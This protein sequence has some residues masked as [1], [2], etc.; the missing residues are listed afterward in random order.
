MCFRST[1]SSDDDD[2]ELSKANKFN[3]NEVLIL[4]LFPDRFLNANTFTW[5]TFR[6]EFSIRRRDCFFPNIRLFITRP[7]NVRFFTVSYPWNGFKYCRPLIW[8]TKTTHSTR[9]YFPIV[10]PKKN[11]LL[12]PPRIDPKLTEAFVAQSIHVILFIPSFIRV[13]RTRIFTIS[14]MLFTVFGL[15]RKLWRKAPIT[16][17]RTQINIIQIMYDFQIIIK[18]KNMV[19]V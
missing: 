16:E 5:Q 2:E 10:F 14:R 11:S 8:P 18:F 1:P 15:I 17:N 9:N 19:L 12:S 6:A 3:V 4:L 13:D 7:T